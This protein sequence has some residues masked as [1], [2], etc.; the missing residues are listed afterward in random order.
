[1]DVRVWTYELNP[2][3]CLDL[4]HESLFSLYSI[5]LLAYERGV[6]GWVL[7]ITW[8]QRNKFRP[9]MR[10]DKNIRLQM[11]HKYKKIQALCQIAKKACWDSVHKSSS[12]N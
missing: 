12:S 6:G 1:M 4:L 11:L 9:W 10:E 5:Q 7:A 8:T 2:D 3:L